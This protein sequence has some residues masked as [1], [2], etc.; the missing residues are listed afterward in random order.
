MDLVPLKRTSTRIEQMHKQMN[1]KTPAKQSTPREF[2]HSSV[3]STITHN[4]YL[5][6]LLITPTA[7]SAHSEYA[8]PT[9][10]SCDRPLTPR[11]YVPHQAR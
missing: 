2:F 8:Y 3:Y 7:P 9:N 6:N 10:A 5:I 11:R 1:E 4:L